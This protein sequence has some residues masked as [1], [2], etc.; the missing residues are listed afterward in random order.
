MSLKMYISFVKECHL[1]IRNLAMNYVNDLTC[2]LQ[3]YVGTLEF[4]KV[5]RVFW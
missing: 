1:F 5:Q 4:F 2:M 3:N